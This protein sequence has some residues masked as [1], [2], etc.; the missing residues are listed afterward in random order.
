MPEWDTLAIQERILRDARVPRG[1]PYDS[2]DALLPLLDQHLRTVIVPKLLDVGEDYLAATQAYPLMAGQG[3]YRLPP[4]SL[5]LLEVSLLDSAGRPR[6]YFSRATTTQVTKFRS[7]NRTRLMGP[8]EFWWF[9]ASSVQVYPAPSVADGSTI[10]L[11]YARRPSRL[12]SPDDCW[13]V[14]EDST[15]SNVLVTGLVPPPPEGTAFDIVKGTPG[16]ESLVDGVVPTSFDED[17]AD[18]YSFAAPG[19]AGASAGDYLCIA[20]TSPVPQVPLDYLTALEH[21]VVAQLQRSAGDLDAAAASEAAL[22]A[23]LAS[24]VS[25]FAPRADEA[26]TIIQH[27]W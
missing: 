12:V 7:Y 19:L 22:Q 26:T 20:G 14:V 1:S 5:R 23:T 10:V 15:P 6:A 17:T 16:F 24:A 13:T 21:S 9:D 8:P 4:R 25:N 18:V 11:R 3:A 27:D 2:L